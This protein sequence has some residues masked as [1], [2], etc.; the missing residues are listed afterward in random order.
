MGGSSN[1]YMS[2]RHIEVR[3]EIQ[4]LNTNLQT[5]LSNNNVFIASGGGKVGIGTTSPLNRLHVETSDSTVARF[6]STTNKAISVQDN[7]L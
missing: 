4:M 6:K 5:Y 2:V 7:D 1:G 3:Q